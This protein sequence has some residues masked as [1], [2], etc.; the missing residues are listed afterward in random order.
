MASQTTLSQLQDEWKQMYQ[1][2]LPSAARCKAPSQPKWPVQLD[3]CFARIILDHVVGIDTPWTQKIQSPAYKNMSCEQLQES[4]ALGRKILE[5][6][7]ALVELDG[8]SLSLR[9][10]KQKSGRGKAIAEETESST[11]A[12][13]GD[14]AVKRKLGTL[15]DMIIKSESGV[16]DKRKKTLLEGPSNRASEEAAIPSSQITTDPERQ[17]DLMPHLRR[18]A[19]SQK[20]AFQKKVLTL[21]CQVPRGEY[22]TYGAMAKHIS[23]SARAVGSALRN[24]PFAPDVPC[25]RVLAS[26]GGL[27]G[28][29]GSWG[30]N[31]KDG[32]HDERKRK[33][34][35]DEGVRFDG[36]GIVVGMPWTGF[37]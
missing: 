10:K 33:L 17:D 36:K 18:I 8:K 34:L 9:G 7:A 35:R 14:S 16:R 31:G 26:G 37:T 3:H 30:R 29:H 19:L 2:A 32:L 11:G 27:G 6:E 5:G 13:T 24:N 20:T 21:L 15:D 1:E 4:I 23:S 12:A 25:H 22:T 28:F